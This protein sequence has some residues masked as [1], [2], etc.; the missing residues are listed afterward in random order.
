MSSAAG[1]IYG[2]VVAPDGFPVSR[3]RI[4]LT[5]AGG[6]YDREF[7]NPDG[8]FYI[9]DVPAG[10]YNFSIRPINQ[11]DIDKLFSFL[12]SN[13]EIKKDYTYGEMYIELQAR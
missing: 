7:D 1:G 11:A 5:N 4:E 2:R 9:K 3:F 6:L 10:K 13:I 8:L 12:I